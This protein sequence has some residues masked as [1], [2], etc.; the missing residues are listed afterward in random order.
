MTKMKIENIKVD[1]RFRQE[2][3]DIDELAESIEKHGLIHPPVVNEDGILIAGERRLRACE[4]LQMDEIEVR[5]LGELSE[6]ERKEMELEENL[7]RKKF[8]WSEEVKAKE[9]IHL[10]KQIQH[11]QRVKGH[12]SDGWGTKDTA[13]LLDESLGTVSQDIKLA[14]AMSDYPELKDC[15]TKTGAWKKLKEIEERETLEQMAEM[16]G[17]KQLSEFYE[18]YNEDV[19]DYMAK[20]GDE[21]F[22]LILADPPWGIE[23]DTKSRLSKESGVEYDDSL[24]YS[25]ALVDEAC[26][27]FYRILKPDTHMYMYFGIANYG[28]FRDIIKDAGF[29]VDPVP[30]IYNKDRGG[31]AAKGKTYPKAYEVIF[32]CWKGSRKLNTTHHNVYTISRPEGYKRIHSAQKPVEM[33]RALVEASTDP[34][35]RVLIPF[36][37]SGSAVIASAKAERYVVGTELDKTTFASAVELIEKQ[38]VEEE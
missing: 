32:H 9:E 38:L 8:T 17:G 35:E 11:G 1:Q 20:Q 22:D 10:I 13:K 12:E 26:R 14:E 21:T 3:G 23:M 27:E 25:I 16:V 24:E 30:V 29:E 6:L 5:K 4:Q 28:I 33:N 7:Y 36:M 37:G 19:L 15:D 18:V 2:F 31:S 34:G